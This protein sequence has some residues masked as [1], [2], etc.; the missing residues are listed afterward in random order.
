MDRIR[1]LLSRIAALF[2]RRSHDA[3]LDD[4]LRAHIEL[5]AA[6]NLR[7]GMSP[8]AAR[9][10]ALRQFGGVAQTS[11]QYRTQRGLPGIETFAKDL[12][13]AV[14]MLLRSPGFT[15]VAVLTLAL[16]IGGNTAI[17][18]IVNGVLLNPLPFPHAEQLVGVHESKPN[19]EG[20]SISF[21]NFLD[22]R[23]DNHSFSA[24]GLARGFSFS[25]TGRG[26]AEQVNAE[27]LSSGFFAVLGVRP[28]LGREF[29]LAEEQRGSA[30]V[31]MISEGLWRR[32][33]AGAANVL[34]QSVTLDGRN[35]A[36][37]GV[38][39]S[40]F[41]LSVPSFRESDVYAPIP[42]WGN[43]FL[44][45]RG[46]G[47]G[48]HGIARLKPGVTF[49]H[50]RADMQSVTRNLAI[51]FPDVDRGIGANLAPL[52]EQIVGHTRPFLLVLLAAVGFVLLI[53][54]VNV[55]SLLLARAA[56]RSRE[57][58][59]RAALGASRARV[60]RQLLT[61]SLLLGLASGLLALIPAIWGTQAALKLLPNALP[62]AY[63]VGPDLR[64]L[65]FSM[66]IS[67]LTGA[68]FG[69]AP[70]LKISQADPN[71]ALKQGGRGAIGSQ[72]RALGAFVVFEMAIALVLLTGAGLMVR[73]L[74]KL[75]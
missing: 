10:A 61:E 57:F 65:A 2:G 72:H 36:I 39:P 67:L 12:R 56:A 69:L 29:S 42:Q 73:S 70:A 45:N 74:V 71:S 51:A 4:E 59:V 62:R 60:V 68:L 38:I 15:I 16:G 8:D 55:A 20:G 7:R 37:V 23:K 27:F 31:A 3:D 34:G 33:F 30:H 9:T 52:K 22:W 75:W 64:V 21:P 46:A 63:E 58:A 26:E 24:M 43:T 35:F 40:S 53:A 19:F 13:Y 49:E 6:E 47:L 5:A 1:T 25:L 54:C 44:M 28:M 14:R 32:K 48:F 11:E 41:R 50:A 18:S 17:F 66:L